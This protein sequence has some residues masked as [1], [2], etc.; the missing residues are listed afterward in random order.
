MGSSSEGHSVTS[1]NTHKSTE[2]CANGQSYFP[3]T[4]SQAR[5]ERRGGRGEFLS[6]HVYGGSNTVEEEI[7]IR[8]SA[9]I[10][11]QASHAS[12]A[13][14]ASSFG[15]GFF[16]QA[17][18]FDVLKES[19]GYETRTISL[20]SGATDLIC[21]LNLCVVR[22]M[23]GTRLVS[24][25]FSDYGGPMM[26]ALDPSS[27]AP[28]LAEAVDALADRCGARY[29]L[30]K[31]TI[32]ELVGP[33][34]SRGFE[35]IE[36]LGTFIVPLR[37][38]FSDI[39]EGFEE[40]VRR[41][42]RK[43]VQDGLEL[44]SDRGEEDIKRFY[45]LY[46]RDMKRHGSPPHKKKYFEKIWEKFGGSNQLRL[47]GCELKGKIMGYA[48]H[49]LF[50]ETA[51]FYMGILPGTARRFG[52]APF[53]IANSIRTFA[54]EGYKFYDFGRTTRGS[55]EYSFKESF[56]GEYHSLESLTKIYS[57]ERYLEPGDWKYKTLSALLR[58]MPL[59]LLRSIGPRIKE[60][61]E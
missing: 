8:A 14:N 20:Y 40:D 26:G 54:V 9:V 25:P 5:F 23:F 33:L 48:L 56:G 46:L 34:V 38:P 47:L 39:E 16:H 11:S 30:F 31:S 7:Q 49:F 50:Q 42:V 29:V 24:L 60:Q 19:Y 18:W 27:A 6:G 3:E 36:Q 35:L 32:P 4:N 10:Q 51:L 45:E 41:R 57:G 12:D 53:L 52:V 37:L 55:G 22:G 61:L 13:L 2:S 43:A 44:T 59:R 21:S 17:R 15:A 1:L 28:A 58:R